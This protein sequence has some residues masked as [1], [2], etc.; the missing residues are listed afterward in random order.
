MKTFF[1]ILFVSLSFLAGLFVGTKNALSYENKNSQAEDT[2]KANKDYEVEYAS[3]TNEKFYQK[4]VEMERNSTL[5]FNGFPTC[6]ASILYT[7]TQPGDE[8]LATETD[9]LYLVDWDLNRADI[10]RYPCYVV[11]DNHDNLW[12]IFRH[13]E[14][15]HLNR[16]DEE[17]YKD[18]L[19]IRKPNYENWLLKA[20]K[21][22]S[23][24]SWGFNLK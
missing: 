18:W 10:N 8:I 1:I 4:M 5:V 14:N 3:K 22:P 20:N 11:K 6:L 9:T 15:F 7:H 16:L 13:N 23:G 17:K 21:E 12:S 24:I 19:E 2:L